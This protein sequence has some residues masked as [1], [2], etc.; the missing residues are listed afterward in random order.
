MNLKLQTTLMQVCKKHRIAPYE[1]SNYHGE[2]ARYNIF[3]YAPYIPNNWN[4]ILVLGTSQNISVSNKGNAE[5]RQ[6]LLDALD[7]D[8]ILRLGNQY[9]SQQKPDKFIGVAPWDE[10]FLK[11]A[12]L[13]CFPEFKAGQFGVSNAYPWELSKDDR[14]K[15]IFLEFKSIA[16]WKDILPVLQPKHII[17][18]G[19][20][21]TMVIRLTYYWRTEGCRWHN[22][23]G[24][25]YF[26]YIQRLFDADDILDRYPE[27]KN[28]IKSNPSLIHRTKRDKAYYILYAAHAVS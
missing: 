6:S 23:L 3:P 12:M 20:A 25:K 10:G 17:C 26:T 4:G 11:L 15:N 7:D 1:Y 19:D 14:N 21:A 18:A 24:Y 22:I 9:V 5:Y 27:V 16:F 8:L 2:P 13:A 28:A